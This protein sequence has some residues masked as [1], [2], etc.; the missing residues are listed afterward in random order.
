MSSVASFE[1][2]YH[3]CL[4]A[5]GQATATLPSFVDDKETVVALYKMMTLLRL[6]DKKAIALQR[7]GRMGTYSSVLGQE[8]IGVAIGHVMQPQDLLAP[9]YREYGAMLQRG[10]RMRDILFYWGGDER[11]M[12]YQGD[13]REDL[14]ICVPIATQVTQAVGV[15]YAFK[16]RGEA[17]VVV[18]ICGDGATSKGDFYEGLNA[19]ALWQLPVLFVVNNNQWAISVPRQQQSHAQTLAQKAIAAG[20]PGEQVDGNDVLAMT[21][22][23]ALA[24]EEIRAGAGPRLIE[25]LTYRLCDHTTADDAQRYRDEDEVA[26]HR[27]AE[28]IVRLRQWMLQ[29]HQWDDDKEQLLLQSCDEQIE[30]E[31]EQYLN[32]PALAAESMFDYLYQELPAAFHAQQRAVKERT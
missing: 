28:P 27:L 2:A 5:S 4:N 16:L 9:A 23:C 3:Q 18:C 10:V 24:L 15:A 26:R 11:G 1:I 22:R 21:D 12:D 32:T 25:A 14:P 7:T 17:R 6:F 13:A 8:A 20:M 19:A 31:V 29:Q 30:A